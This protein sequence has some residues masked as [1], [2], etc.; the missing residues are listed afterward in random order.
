[1]KGDVTKFRQAVQFYVR[2]LM[3]CNLYY[4]SYA[5]IDIHHS[6]CLF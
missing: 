3:L 4:I 1:M 6:F 5:L 2:N